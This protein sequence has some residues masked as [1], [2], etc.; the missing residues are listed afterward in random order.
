[1]TKTQTWRLFGLLRENETLRMRGFSLSRGQNG[2][3][4]ID[5]SGHVRGIWD[6]DG[7][8]YTWVTPGS[9]EP[10]FRTDDPKSAVLYTVVTLLQGA[11]RV[12]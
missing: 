4:V 1:M 7:N 8:C 5:R 12:R 11:D 6:F 9:S 3:I 10:I 2:G